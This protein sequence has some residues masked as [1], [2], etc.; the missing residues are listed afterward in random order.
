MRQS[1]H[2][3]YRA[4]AGPALCALL[5]ASGHAHGAAPLL[6]ALLFAAL[7]FNAGSASGHRA[8]IAFALAGAVFLAMGFGL[9][10]GFTPVTL[11]AMQVNS[12]KALA[13]LSALAMF[14]S[15]WQWN[16]RCSIIAAVC[17]L[18]V[19]LLASA[20]GY[21]HWA[22]AAPMTVG[23]FALANGFG[24]IAEEWFFRLWVQR[25]LQRFGTAPSLLLTALLFGLVHF[26]GGPLFIA[27]AALAGLAYAAVYQA[28]SNSVWAAV[29]L[30]LALNV[31]R[32][33]CF[34]L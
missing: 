11:G 23:W 12:G 29:A 24:T 9:V 17:L 3:H 8:G 6:A 18:A 22:P 2:H 19:P 20:I 15:H 30:H 21:V 25:P 33:A 5:Y 13:G 28:S 14:P 26:G 34:G 32:A 27:L 1:R 7:L 4:A 31:L 16:R 10:P